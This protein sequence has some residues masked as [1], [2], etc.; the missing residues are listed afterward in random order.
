[1]NFTPVRRVN[2]YEQIVD[3]IEQS[4]VSGKLRVGD[5]LPGERRLMEAFSVSRATVREA[6]RVLHATG[7]VDSRPGDPRGPV[8]LPFSSAVLEGPLLRMAYQEDASRAELLQFRLVIEGQA[9]LLAAVRHAADDLD[10]IDRAVAGLE[11]L[12]R[13]DDVDPAGFGERLREFHRAIRRASGNR[14]LEACGA[15]VQDV[16]TDLAKRRLETEVDRAA[17]VRRSAADAAALAARV[18]AGDAG[19][20]QQAATSNIYRYYRDVL[21]EDERAV[22]EPLT[23]GR[24]EP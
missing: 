23:G 19:G 6:M 3:Q 20:A 12:A 11:D 17:R 1:M 5:R 22:L 15:A 8:V 21:T 2:A 24:S 18:R 4:V 9:A 16:L 14:L 10:L 7:V 13:A